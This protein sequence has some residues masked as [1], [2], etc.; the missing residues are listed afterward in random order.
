MNETD[1]K[2]L[3]EI[4]KDNK[5]IATAIKK[6]PKQVYRSIKILKELNFIQDN[7]EL[8]RNPFTN[9]IARQLK[10]NP[11]LPKILADSGL[12]ILTA[13]TTSKTIKELPFKKSILYRKI[14]EAKTI[15]LI[16][17]KDKYYFIPD[18]WQELKDFLRIYQEYQTDLRIPPDAKI[19]YKENQIVL[20]STDKPQQSNKT[21]FSRYEE[22]GI[23]LLL[24]EDYYYLPKKYLSIKEIFFHSL[25]IAEKEQEPRL[26]LYLTLFYLKHKLH[27]HH[28]VL[29]NIKKLLQGEKIK[30]YPSLAEIKEKAKVYDIII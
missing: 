20:Y 3:A 24:P 1:W 29:E 22:F 28:P 12:K 15:S 11:H 25:Q 23:K 17:K 7:A 16:T 21:A 4:C 30:N 5:N 13:L 18:F 26:F 19:Y 27:L 8:S 14:K 2:V 9:I 10:A 6:S